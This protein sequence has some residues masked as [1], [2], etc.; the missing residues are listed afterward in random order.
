MKCG[1]TIWI[2]NKIKT[3]NWKPTLRSGLD[4]SGKTAQNGFTNS[5]NL[6]ERKKRRCY[7]G[8]MFDVNIVKK[9]PR[10]HVKSVISAI[11]VQFLF[12][13]KIIDADWITLLTSHLGRSQYNDPSCVFFASLRFSWSGFTPGCQLPLSRKRTRSRDFRRD[14]E[15]DVRGSSSERN[16][17]SNPQ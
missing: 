3:Q 5:R 4:I 2:F 11:L 8:F 16:Y 14:L 17:R 13:Q 10:R 9:C 7:W 15:C 6:T 12:Q 1:N